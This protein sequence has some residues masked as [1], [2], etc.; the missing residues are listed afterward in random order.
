MSY[1]RENA[2]PA[3]L[4]KA[5]RSAVVD[6]VSDETGNRK[7]SELSG[8]QQRRVEI[9]RALLK[10]GE[11]FLFDEITSELDTDTTNRLLA[12]LAEETVGKT[13]V[14]VSHDWAE[15]QQAERILV[16]DQGQIVQD[17]KT[18]ALLQSEGLFRTLFLSEVTHHE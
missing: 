8:G 16:V 7:A 10:G 11:I 6:F 17:G 18:E 1:G 4:Q 13:V 15:I 9:A 14:F 3:Q 5:F 12:G 2:T